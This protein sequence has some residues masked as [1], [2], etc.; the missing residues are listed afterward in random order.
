[1]GFYDDEET[2]QQY[3]A[4]AEGYDGRELIEILRNHLPG[5]GVQGHQGLSGSGHDDG[6]LAVFDRYAE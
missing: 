4:I 2:A 1:M 5:G 3:I 6:L